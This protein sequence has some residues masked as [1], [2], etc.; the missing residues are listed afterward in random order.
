MRFALRSLAL[1]AV[2]TAA[3]SPAFA[4]VTIGTAS[5]A[6]C[7]PFGCPGSFGGTRYQQVYAG[8]AFSGPMWINAIRF[9][10]TQWNPGNA[11]FPGVSFALSFSTTTSVTPSNI[12]GANLAANIGANNALFFSQ[13]L[14]G[15]ATAWVSGAPYY[16]DPSSGN[17]LM[18]VQWSGSGFS[19]FLDAGF[20]A[21]FG[22]AYDENY[23]SNNVTYTYGQDR[24][25]GL[26]TG[27][28]ATPTV[29][30]EPVTMALM[31]TGLAGIGLIRRRRRKTTDA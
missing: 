25:Y 21:D 15:P 26:V 16:Y 12:S 31:G 6:N 29:T 10:N 1:A 3:S 20:S 17:L 2:L 9:F 18:D 23:T 19:G 27:F 28:D 24:N 11:T 22:R 4:Q 30:P 7:A 8:S 13:V 5:T 14:T